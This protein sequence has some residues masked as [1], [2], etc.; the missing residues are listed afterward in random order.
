MTD[1]APER[2]IPPMP[3]EE[4]A[5][6]KAAIEQRWSE[7]PW[8]KGGDDPMGSPGCMMRAQEVLALIAAA[9][10]NTAP[11]TREDV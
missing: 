7:K 8:Y 3:P 11:E 5:K 9:E 6:L 1:D 10:A 2:S 4:I